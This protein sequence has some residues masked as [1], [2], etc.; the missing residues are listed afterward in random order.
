MLRFTIR[1]LLWLTAVAALG[2]SWWIDRSR[3]VER[4]ERLERSQINLGGVVPRIIIQPEEEH[5][6]R[7][8]LESS[9]P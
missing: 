9:L 6:L 5:A 8:P 3:L 2:V 4:I 1:E 7:I